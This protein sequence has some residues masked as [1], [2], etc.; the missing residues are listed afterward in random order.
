MKFAGFSGVAV[1]ELPKP[2]RAVE[3][4]LW[5]DAGEVSGMAAGFGAQ[6]KAVK[7]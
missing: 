7:D 5:S 6:V 4:L 2:G 1:T 3:K